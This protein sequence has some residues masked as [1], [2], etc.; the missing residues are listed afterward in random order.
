M[1]AIISKVDSNL[2]R[3]RA[4][5]GNRSATSKL[6]RYSFSPQVAPLFESRYAFAFCRT[7]VS[8]HYRIKED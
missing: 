1:R 6:T 3:Y 7:P 8:A 2:R 4:R 5:F